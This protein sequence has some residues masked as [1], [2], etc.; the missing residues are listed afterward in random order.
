HLVKQTS[1]HRDKLERRQLD[2]ITVTANSS[3]VNIRLKIGNYCKV[4]SD[5]ELQSGYNASLKSIDFATLEPAVFGPSQYQEVLLRLKRA[6]EHLA[7]NLKSQAGF[8][9]IAR[10]IF[11]TESLKIG[12]Y[13]YIPGGRWRPS[14]CL[15]KWKVAIV[16]PFRDRK[17]HLAILIN[18]LIPF[19]QNQKLEFGFFIGEQSNNLQFNRGLMKNIGYRAATL[20]GDWD[21]VI[22]HDTDLIPMKGENFYGCNG[23]PRHLAAYTEQLRYRMPYEDIFGGVVGLTAEQVRLSNGYSNAYWGWGGEDDELS[24]RLKR[25]GFQ[26]TRETE[27]GYYR[28]LH[29]KEKQKT[30]LCPEVDCLYNNFQMRADWEGINNMTYSVDNLELFPLYTKISVD[31]QKE[32]WNSNMPPCEKFSNHEDHNHDK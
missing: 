11:Y 30:Q 13:D 23:F 29:H 8:D 24:V 17:V 28:S 21:C 15:P 14:D 7:K 10:E 25:K 20:F 27:H 18:N 16:V 4:P 26:I 32:A 19:L 9:H 22:F 1:R 12:N 6:N 2:N 5:N 3:A 31:I